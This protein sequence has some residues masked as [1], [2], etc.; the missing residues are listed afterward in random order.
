LEL[1]PDILDWDT[2]NAITMNDMF[3]QAQKLKKIPDIS[4]WI[5]SKVEDFSYM[6]AGCIELL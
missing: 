5:T 4:K 3:F 6:F 1:L 2:R